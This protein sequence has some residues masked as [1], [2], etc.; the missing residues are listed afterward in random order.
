MSETSRH[1]D[2]FRLYTQGMGL[3]IGYGGAPI[4]DHAIA[5]DQVVKYADYEGKPQHLYGTATNLYWFRDNVLDFVYSSHLIEDFVNPKFVLM[6][7]T[8]VIVKGGH[9]CLLFPDEQHYRRLT[10]PEYWNLNHKHMDMGLEFM[11]SVV[12][13]IPNLTMIE[14]GEFLSDSDYNCMIVCRK[15]Y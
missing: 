9:L 2:K 13:S 3:D 14:A 10:K 1:R 4:H 15:D 8:R 7:W 6:E 11:L 12:R 5:M